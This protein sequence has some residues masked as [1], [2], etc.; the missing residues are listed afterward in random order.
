MRRTDQVGRQIQRRQRKLRFV[1]AR[2]DRV[3]SDHGACPT[4]APY[5]TY[6]TYLTYLAHPARLAHPSRLT[7]PARLACP[8]R[9]AYT[10]IVPSPTTA[11]APPTFTPLTSAPEP[12][13][14]T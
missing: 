6:L 9:P 12:A 3:V 14:R 13:T 7:H 8:A 11:A 1:F 5:L 4:D 10:V 2:D